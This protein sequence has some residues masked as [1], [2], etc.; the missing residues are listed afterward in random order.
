MS[1]FTA[2]CKFHQQGKCTRGEKCK[3]IH[4]DSGPAVGVP[5]DVPSLQSHLGYQPPIFV[6]IS[7]DTPIFCIDVE[8]GATSRDHN[9]RTPVAIGVADGFG[10]PVCKLLV[11]EI[12]DKPV[13]SYLTPITGVTRE[14]V[15]QHGKPFE[16]C[17][18]IVRSH[19]NPRA[20]IIGQNI[21]KDM[22]WL[23]LQEGA[24]YAQLIDLSA[25]FRVWNTVRGSWTIFS[26]DHVAK[27][28]LNV[29]DRPTHDALDDALL[30]MGLFNTYRQVQLDPQRLNYMQMMTINAPITPSFA[31]RQGAIEDCCVGH[32]KSCICGGAFFIS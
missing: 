3:F 29:A 23:G 25:L 21:L 16:E 30:S 2:V 18:S 22:H 31:S 8:C 4:A 6:Q 24:D 12:E 7:N 13:L 15:K 1:N 19:L 27:V 5:G 28:W 26:L 11:K 9:G 32:K 10:R 17:I 20:V 14:E